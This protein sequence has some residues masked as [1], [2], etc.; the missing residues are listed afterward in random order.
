MGVEFTKIWWPRWIATVFGK[1]PHFEGIYLGQRIKF[2][3]RDPEESPYEYQL[4]LYHPR[5][6][7]LGL[8]CVRR[9]SFGRRFLSPPVRKSL[10]ARRI[11]LE[12]E[13]GVDCWAYDREHTEDLFREKEVREAMRYV[14]GVLERHGEVAFRF[15]DEKMVL[16]LREGLPDAQTLSAMAGLSSTLANARSIPTELPIGLRAGRMVGRALLWFVGFLILA[17]VIAILIVNVS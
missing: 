4:T 6:L 3:Q 2:V 11:R 7:N 10:L 13:S 1:T 12:E 15:D 9:V 16:E 17:L 14:L 5:A 8:L